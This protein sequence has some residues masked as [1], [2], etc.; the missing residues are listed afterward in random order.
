M[1]E[2][3]LDLYGLSI[4]A[5]SQISRK[6]EKKISFAEK[7]KIIFSK[8]AKNPSIPRVK[9]RTTIGFFA[10]LCNRSI[11]FKYQIY[12]KA[13]SPLNYRYGKER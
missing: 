5:C 11:I 2:V 1:A 7:D 9:S 4:R 13:S 6:S 3:A 12:R 8:K 10:F